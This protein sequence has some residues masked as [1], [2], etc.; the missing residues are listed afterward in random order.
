[1]WLAFQSILDNKLGATRVLIV[2]KVTVEGPVLAIREL[3][4][5]ILSPERN[6]TK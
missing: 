4:V 6:A 5:K 2:R 3:I 1:M